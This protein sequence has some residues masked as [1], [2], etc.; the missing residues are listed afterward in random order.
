[1]PAIHPDRGPAAAARLTKALDLLKQRRDGDTPQGATISELCRLAG[2]SRNAV[3]RYHPTVLAELR[4]QQGLPPRS[5]GQSVAGPDVALLQDQLSKLAALVDHYYTAYRET[6]VLL[7][8]RD[9]QLAELRR[10]WVRAPAVLR[11]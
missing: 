9:R 1:M 5:A 8:R 2:V 6:S 7:E 10:K 3:Y 11:P 4:R